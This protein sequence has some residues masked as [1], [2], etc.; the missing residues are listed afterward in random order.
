MFYKIYFWFFA[1]CAVIY[2]IS[3]LLNENFQSSLLSNPLTMA[4]FLC[5]ILIAVF[6]STGLYLYAYDEDWLPLSFW[7]IFSV[8]YFSTSLFSYF[9]FYMHIHGL[10]DF[11]S[12]L[13]GL[14]GTIPAYIAL[15]SYSFAKKPWS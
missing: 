6:A 4:T 10:N 15:L 1:V 5:G 13:V 2:G 7:K 14:L 12:S 9:Y 11:I 8:F 3:K